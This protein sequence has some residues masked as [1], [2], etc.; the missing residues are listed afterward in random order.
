MITDQKAR[1]FGVN[2]KTSS[3]TSPPST[4]R[5]SSSTDKKSRNSP[6][7]HPSNAGPSNY[8]APPY[9]SPSCSQQPA[10]VHPLYGTSPQISPLTALPR[11]S[12][13]GLGRRAGSG[14]S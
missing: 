4:G 1:K 2:I 11:S 6:P 5:P 9:H 8:S 7:P 14:V 3:T 10:P 12:K 13:F